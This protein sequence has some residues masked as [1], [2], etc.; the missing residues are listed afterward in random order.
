MNF[1]TVILNIFNSRPDC[2]L[3]SLLQVFGEQGFVFTLEQWLLP[4]GHLSLH[5]SNVVLHL[6]Y[7]IVNFLHANHALLNEDVDSWGVP[8]EVG[9]SWLK[10][11]VDLL[12]ALGEKG[13]FNG[14]KN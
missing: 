4:L 12:N 5:L 7:E 1:L 9:D 8:A 13:L 2:G 10:T 6:F 11:C 3:V 14:Q